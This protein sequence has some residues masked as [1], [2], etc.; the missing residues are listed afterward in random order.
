MKKFLTLSLGMLLTT[1]SVFSF[2][3][4]HVT[5]SPTPDGNAT[6]VVI[7][8]SQDVGGGYVFTMVRNN[9]Y[10]TEFGNGSS[11]RSCYVDFEDTSE[12][13]LYATY[14]SMISSVVA[15]YSSYSLEISAT[16]ECKNFY[17][18]EFII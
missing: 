16:G 2:A 11:Y 15:R 17:F 7:Q 10:Y 1:M 8:S 5:F 18:G 12:A 4:I 6:N 13:T 9:V 14:H 3:E